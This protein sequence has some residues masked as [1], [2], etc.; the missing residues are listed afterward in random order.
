MKYQTVIEITIFVLLLTECATP[1]TKTTQTLLTV[2]PTSIPLITTSDVKLLFVYSPG[3][4]QSANQTPIIV[5]FG[6]KNPDVEVIQVSHSD[7][8]NEQEGLISGIIGYPIMVFHDENHV[9]RIV[10]ETSMATLEEEYRAFKEQ[11]RDPSIT[12]ITSGSY[13]I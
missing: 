12:T 3:C 11:P 8:N 1:V 9:R 2:T 4:S 10:G 13:S 5:E 6:E 7:L